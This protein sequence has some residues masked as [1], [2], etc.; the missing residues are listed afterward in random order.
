[1]TAVT[2]P[3]DPVPADPLTPPAGPANL[4][5]VRLSHPFADGPLLLYEPERMRT[6]LEAAQRGAPLSRNVL[7]EEDAVDE[8]EVRAVE[9]RYR[10]TLQRRARVATGWSI[11][12]WLLGPAL[13]LLWVNVGPALAVLFFWLPPLAALIGTLGGISGGRLLVV[14]VALVPLA[15]A[16]RRAWAHA[17]EARRWGR[18]ARAAG[19]RRLRDAPVISAASPAV[20]EFAAASGTARTR[21]QEILSALADKGADAAADGA[22]QARSLYQ[23]AARHGLGAAAGA[24]H[25]VYAQLD[26]AEQRAAKAERGGGGVLTERRVASE[27]RRARGRALAALTP[28]SPVAKV[29]G[30]PL[31]PLVGTVAGLLA[32]AASVFITGLYWVEPDQAAIVDPPGARLARAAGAVGLGGALSSVLSSPD[33]TEVN[34]NPGINWGWPMPFAMRHAIVLG[35]QRAQV[36]AIFRQTGPDSFDG[37]VIEI[38]FRVSDVQRWAQVDKDGDGVDVLSSQLSALFQGVLLRSRQDARQVV[39]QQNPDLANDQQQLAARADQLLES[40][41]DDLVRTF[42]SA[43]SSAPI[44]QQA[45]IQ[46]SNQSRWQM[47]HGIPGDVARAALSGQ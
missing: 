12:Y 6:A 7:S 32:L 40:R 5:Y 13:S 19:S 15:W 28:F 1:M 17:A 26:A 41:M 39:A 25:A 44:A 30:R 11:F 29:R 20:A 47:V 23:L 22:L 42:V 38:R 3:S 31:A 24:Y 34:R 45:G 21:L 9:L 37:V 36:R 33:A 27:L 8:R 18:L 43:L 2:A 14:I 10:R 4:T 35:E 46:I 16:W